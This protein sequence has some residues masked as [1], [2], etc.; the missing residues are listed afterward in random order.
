[1]SALTPVSGVPS[2]AVDFKDPAFV[3]DP[4][5]VLEE[6]RA[7]GPLVYHPELNYYMITSYRESARVMGKAEL[8]ASD[9]IHFSQLFGGDTMECLDNPRHD[10][11]RSIWSHQFQRGTLEEQRA[12]VERT[13]EGR[14]EVVREK[15]RTDGQVNAVTLLTRA[16]P[17]I[18]I[19]N[20]MGV[21]PEYFEQFVEWSDAM[22]GILEARDNTTAEGLEMVRRGKQASAELNDYL[23][24]IVAERR[25]LGV[26]DDLVSL[27]ANSDVPM[28][29]TE[30]VASN[31]Q[32]VFAGNETTSK[33][34][35]YVIVALATHPEQREQVR[36]NRSLVAQAIE[37]AHRWTSVLV[38]N[39][40]FVKNDGTPVE[41]VEL[42]EGA[43][44]MLFQA[45]ANRDP[46]RWD[47]P[48]AFDV[49]RPQK[50]HLGFGSGLHSCLGLNLA[51]LETE[52]MINRMLDEIPDWSIAGDVSYGTNFMVRGPSDIQLCL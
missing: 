28:S 38:F 49:H 12:L 3:Q 16:V 37:E 5:P 36:L 2:M 24:K 9:I 7:A 19:A 13:V 11:V 22:G 20:M 40:R 31:T 46:L 30:V 15:L 44:V 48:T 35:G 4:Y 23:V 42:P 25:R 10:Q 8:F 6:I 41:G 39:L 1:M 45:A 34:M 43:T 47:N 18:V 21:P 17:T 27:M 32:L 14:M 29:D 50:A 51:R 33:L 26:G 52:V